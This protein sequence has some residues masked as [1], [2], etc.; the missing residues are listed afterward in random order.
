MLYTRT[1]SR[2]SVEL[3]ILTLILSKHR[4][5]GFAHCAACRA[6]EAPE[7]TASHAL[8]HPSQYAQLA[9]PSS[10]K[11]QRPQVALRGSTARAQGHTPVAWG[12]PAVIEP[13]GRGRLPPRRPR[14]R[15]CG[16]FRGV[17]RECWG[18]ANVSFVFRESLGCSRK[19]FSCSAECSGWF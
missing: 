13:T 10:P 3:S 5:C 1:A 17:F 2:P 8:K 4:I 15:M 11:R 6:L 12:P 19:C 14:A 7:D 16:V 18:R 9:H